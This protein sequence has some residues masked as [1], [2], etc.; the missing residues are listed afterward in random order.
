[1]GKTLRIIFLISIIFLIVLYIIDL[2]QPIFWVTVLKTFAYMVLGATFS[3][4]LFGEIFGN[5]KKKPKRKK[6]K[7]QKKKKK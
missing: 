5:K 2:W 6:K 1:M 4:T 7:K 3:A